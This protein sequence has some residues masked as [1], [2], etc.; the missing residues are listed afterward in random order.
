MLKFLRRFGKHFLVVG[1]SLL[2]IAW[3]VP[4]AMHELNNPER[5]VVMHVN[6][7]K[8]RA[9]EFAQWQKEFAALRNLLGGNTLFT[10]AEHYMLLSKSA[11]RA[12]LVGGPAEGRAA[13]PQIAEQRGQLEAVSE[14]YQQN[15]SLRSIDPSYIARFIDPAKV[16]AATAKE[17]ALLNDNLQ[18]AANSPLSTREIEIALARLRGIARLTSQYTRVARVSRPRALLEAKQALEHVTVDAIFVSADRNLSEAGEPDDAA[19]LAH[20]DRFKGNKPGEGEFGIGYLLPPRVKIQYMRLDRAAIAKK[21]SPDIKDLKRLFREDYTPAKP[22]ETF[23][24]ARPALDRLYRE[25][26][27]NDILGYADQRF[28]TEI[29]LATRGLSEDPDTGLRKLPADWASQRPDMSGLAHQIVAAVEEK[30]RSE[31]SSAGIRIDAPE[32]TTLESQFLTRDELQAL[33]GIGTS[34][35]LRGSTQES[36]ADYVLSVREL[37]PKSTQLLQVGVPFDQPTRD[38]AGNVYYITVLDARGESVPGSV[39]ESRSRL[40]KE[41]KRLQAYQLLADRDLEAL[42][43]RAISEGLASLDERKPTIPG[44]PAP[45]TDIKSNLNVARDS[46]SPPA[47]NLDVAAF[48]D[49]VFEIASKFSPTQ[50]LSAVDVA[51]RTV[52]VP[53][54]QNLGVGVALIKS[55]TPVTFEAFRQNQARLVMQLLNEETRDLQDSPYTLE[56]LRKSYHVTFPNEERSEDSE[57]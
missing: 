2:L 15:P 18:Q 19:L 5:R 50:D 7:H 37:A 8:V 46:I 14:F 12:G 25:K 6:G 29:A 30:T 27:I 10:T 48:R 1:G 13:I 28:R 11:E 3:L 4:S 32:V 53:I 52:A 45:P 31:G 35:R 24:E 33:E 40:V 36:F 39:T 42:K 44:Q 20:M 16:A 21:I 26:V 54:P 56:R 43:Q 23:E 57:S 41:W 9:K 17:E 22:G 51:E 47:P 34:S 38:A 55:I 49:R